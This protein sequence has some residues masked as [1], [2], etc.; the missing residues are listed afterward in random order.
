M[1]ARTIHT[2]SYRRL[3]SRLRSWRTES[4]QTQRDL[5]M[6]LKKPPSYVHK[7]EVGERRVDPLEFIAWCRACGRDPATSLRLVESDR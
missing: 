3:C 1:G 2:P 6:K 4:G 5:A 7:T